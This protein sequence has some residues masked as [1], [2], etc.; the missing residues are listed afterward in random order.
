VSR[1]GCLARIR[2][3]VQRLNDK[4][5]TAQSDV[6]VLEDQLRATSVA[7]ETWIE[8]GDGW[9]LGYFKL[10]SSWRIGFLKQHVPAGTPPDPWESAPRAVRLRA[11]H[12][13]DKLVE[14]IADAA[15]QLAE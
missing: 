13:L 9:E 1:E 8:M 4:S 2:A 10:A 15:E 6:R 3:A 12:M 5:V 14:A 7:I 11:W